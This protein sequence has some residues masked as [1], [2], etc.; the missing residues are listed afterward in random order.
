MTPFTTVTGPAAPLMLDNVDTD[1]IIR[2]NR[3]TALRRDELGPY[4]LEALRFA[5]DGDEDSTCIL[6]QPPFRGAPLLLAGRNFGCGSSREGAVWALGS[7]GVRCVVAE[8]FGDIFF[9]NC[10]QN[11]ML[12]VVLPRAVLETLA[13]QAAGG[14]PITVDLERC[15]VVAPDGREHPFSIDAIKRA[16]LLDGL[17]EVTRTLARR[18]AIAAWQARDRSAR[19]W[20]WQP[21]A[22]PAA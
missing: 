11:G 7:Y 19:P 12:P 9:G 21:V 3:L 17:D 14:Q 22:R 10:F 5:P 20:V 2:I 13:A 15:L 6:N 16:G 4:A 1:V 8:S 18:A